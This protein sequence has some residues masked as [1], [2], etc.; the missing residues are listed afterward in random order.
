MNRQT[1]FTSK[2]L[3]A[4]FGTKAFLLPSVCIFYH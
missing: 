3:I 2:I 1:V 4:Y